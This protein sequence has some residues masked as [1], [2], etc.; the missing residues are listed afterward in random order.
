M[1]GRFITKDPVLSPIFKK[2][3]SCATN[4]ITSL[5]GIPGF[6]K[7]IKDPRN[8]NPYVYAYAN[9]IRYTDSTGL[10][11]TGVPDYPFGFNFEPC[12]QE[13]DA[14][15]SGCGKTRKEC[16]TQLYDCMINQCANE[17]EIGGRRMV[18][19]TWARNYYIGVRLGGWNFYTGP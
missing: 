10:S 19:E 5:G 7:L 11:C 16:D 2:L 8:F 6:E 12:C 13:H 9:P 18:C 1:A 14:C 17:R 3:H 15:Y 4:K